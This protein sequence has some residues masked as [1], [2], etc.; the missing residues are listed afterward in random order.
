MSAARSR[1]HPAGAIGQSGAIVANAL[2]VSSTGGAIT[3]NNSGNSFGTLTVATNGSDNAS[4]KDSTGVTVASANV[5]GTFTLTSGGAIGQSGAIVATALD[6]SSTGGAI[7]LNNSGNSFGT[8]TVATNGS[9]NASVK[10]STGVTVASANVGGTFT[11]ASGGAIGQSGAIVATAL[12]VSS[13]GGA[14]TLTNSGNSFGTL[15][16]TT[17]GSNNASVN[18]SSGVTV[19]AAHVGGTF[20]LNSAGAI[21]Q[22][23]PIIAN[24]LN[25]TSTGGAITLN[26]PGNAFG[27]LTLSSGAYGATVYDT[28]NLTVNAATA[29]GGLTLLTKGNLT[30]VNSVQVGSGNLLAVAGWDGTTVDPVTVTTGNAYGNNG[31]SIIIGGAGASGGVAVGAS[32]AATLAASTITLSAVNGYAQFG[33]HGSGA[34]VLSAI[35]KGDIAL[36]AGA[37]TGY[38]AQIGNGGYQATGSNGGTIT[39][40][41]GGN[42]NLAAGSGTDAYAQI[43]NGGSQ[44]NANSAG[45]GDTGAISVAAAN[46]NISAGS[47]SAAYSQIGNGGY[48]V[49][50]GLTGT[51]SLTGQIGVTVS[52]NVNVNGGGGVNA[53]AQIGNGGGF[54]N[55]NAGASAHGT[56]S[57]D[58]TVTAPPSPAGAVTVAGGAGGNAYAQIGNGGYSSNAPSAAPHGN[59]VIGGNVTV[60]DLLLAGGNGGSFAYSQIGNGD[61]SHSAL[62]DISGNIVIITNG[63]PVTLNQGSAFDSFA[64]IGNATGTGSVT[65]NITGYTPPQ[66]TA[67]GTIA[68]LTTTPPTVPTDSTGN[69]LLLVNGQPQTGTGTPGSGNQAGPLEDLTDG[70]GSGQQESSDKSDKAADAVADSLD[71]STKKATSEIYFGGLLTKLQSAPPSASPHGVPPADANYSSWGNEAFWQ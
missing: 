47:G 10:D 43:G 3:L 44:S 68:S 34:G 7:T 67:N 2:D 18:D 60:S 5:G 6:V 52:H 62:G 50:A 65:G 28:A 24:A 53:Y 59:F 61:L 19:A 41:A 30:F 31:G 21:G 8:L 11:L 29:N 63:G 70:S 13:T 35:A 42:V 45:Y 66:S 25:V 36:N 64:L 71:G 37:T 1:W 38:D 26:D 22:N 69:T 54:A 39:I 40:A 58:I 17:S 12:D 51:A 55:T 23:D 33:M 46:V 49:G 15:T 4:V 48:S 16:V 56:T 14:I 20:T 32:G 9:D 27:A 57:G